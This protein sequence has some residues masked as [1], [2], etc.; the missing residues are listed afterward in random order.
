MILPTKTVEGRRDEAQSGFTLLELM[1]VLLI[2]ALL[3][4]IAAPQVMKHLG[5]AKAQTAKIQVQALAASVEYLHMDLGRYPTESE[6]LQS[7]VTSPP[8][9]T[10]WDGPYVKQAD[11]LTDPWGRPYLYRF[12]GLHG[13]FDVYTL[14]ADGVEGGSGD[15]S[16]VGNW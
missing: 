12:P 7:L 3:A 11:S 8:G 16:D 14:G 6:G 1:V 10:T 13:S 5:R 9:A 15:A 4:T 2:L